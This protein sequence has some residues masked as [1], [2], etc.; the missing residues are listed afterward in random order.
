[1]VNVNGELKLT[2]KSKQLDTLHDSTPVV[3]KHPQPKQT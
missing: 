1:M 3:M 2:R